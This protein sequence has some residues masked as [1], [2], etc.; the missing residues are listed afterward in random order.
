[1]RNVAVAFALVVPLASVAVGDKTCTE[2]KTISEDTAGHCCWE[3]QVWAKGHCVGKPISCPEE[4]DIDE[5]A[6][7]C[8]P[9]KCPP[10][11]D[12]ILPDTRVDGVHCCF[13]GQAWSKTRHQCV[14]KPAKCPEDSDYGVIDGREG[15]Y[16]SG[17]RRL[18]A[19][20]EERQR[21]MNQ[22]HHISGITVHAPRTKPDG[23]PW[24][25]GGGD[26][27]P[28]LYIQMSQAQRSIGASQIARNRFD[29]TFPVDLTID[30]KEGP[31]T[32]TIL[33]QDLVNDDFVGKILLEFGSGAH[34]GSHPF[35]DSQG[36][37]YITDVPT[38]REQ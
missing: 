28:D 7:A 10:D 5:G 31:L 15:C 11:R 33:D 1:M 34:G 13:K 14:G 2:G 23:R 22:I 32:I 9:K 20:D 36:S 18:A 26:A 29:A 24:D 38:P 19:H 12:G 6:G 8:V 27:P 37:V 21:W 35:A 3:G 30:P 16:S 17:E 4:L 25:A